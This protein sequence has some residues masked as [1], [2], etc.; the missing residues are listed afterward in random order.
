MLTVRPA[1]SY[2]DVALVLGTSDPGRCQCTRHTLGPPDWTPST[3]KE[4][5]ADLTARIGRSQGLLAR[6]D[7]EPVG[8]CAVAPRVAYRA[9]LTSRSPV[10]WKGR[11]EDPDDDGV[12]AVTCFVTRTGYR[13]RGVSA[14]L[15]A[16]TVDLARSQGARAVEAYPM[17]VRAGKTVTW[18]ELHVGSRDVF[19]DAGYVEVSRPTLR[20]VVMRVELG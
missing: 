7:D 14:A 9:L 18:G 13:R 4:R 5:V 3:R 2:D 20:R 8:W 10:L 11:Q 15:A 12:W 16:A 1:T 6:L 19:A 17:V